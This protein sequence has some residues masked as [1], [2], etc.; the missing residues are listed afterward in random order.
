MCGARL[1]LTTCPIWVESTLLTN[2]SF[3]VSRDVRASGVLLYIDERLISP[4]AIVSGIVSLAGAGTL[5]RA[6]DSRDFLE[7][8]FG[9]YVCAALPAESRDT[10]T[11]P[12]LLLFIVSV[13]AIEARRGFRTPRVLRGA[14]LYGIC[15]SPNI[16]SKVWALVYI[17]ILSVCHSAR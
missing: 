9:G 2:F 15:R 8:E 12:V 6:M 11:C 16:F 1:S 3:Q 5:V 4:L 17:S 14:S 13:S 7:R 10:E